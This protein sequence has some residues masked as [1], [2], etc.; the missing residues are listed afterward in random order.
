MTDAAVHILANNI[1]RVFKKMAREVPLDD[2][3]STLVDLINHG[4][5]LAQQIETE[6][7]PHEN[8][9]QMREKLR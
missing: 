6:T 1:R 9:K 5:S 4:D 8:L 2:E 7:D 3:H